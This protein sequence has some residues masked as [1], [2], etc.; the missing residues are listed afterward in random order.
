MTSNTVLQTV[1]ELTYL[2]TNINKTSTRWNENPYQEDSNCMKNTSS[3]DDL[4]QRI[5][6]LEYRNIQLY[7]ID[8]KHDQW[9]KGCWNNS[10]AITNLIYH[11]DGKNVVSF[12]IIIDGYAT[13]RNA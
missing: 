7:G 4:I 2:C 12:I 5:E 13:A 8:W 3:S 9:L 10:K 6:M 11:Y 1:N